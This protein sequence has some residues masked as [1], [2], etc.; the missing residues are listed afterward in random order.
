MLSLIFQSFSK[1]VSHSLSRC[2]GSQKST[3]LYTIFSPI[4]K[5]RHRALS[6]LSLCQV[7]QKNSDSLCPKEFNIFGEYSESAVMATKL[8][9]SQNLRPSPKQVKWSWMLLQTMGQGH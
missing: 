6:S 4:A 3:Q 1:P 9:R 8:Q 2:R 7:L 5:G